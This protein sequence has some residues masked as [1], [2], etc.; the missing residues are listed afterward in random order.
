MFTVW[1]CLVQSCNIS[2]IASLS[3]ACQIVGAV[4][5]C[6][7]CITD[8]IYS[9]QRSTCQE[10]LQRFTTIK[11]CNSKLSKHTSCQTDRSESDR[12]GNF[13][14][15]WQIDKPWWGDQCSNFIT[16]PSAYFSV[17][18]LSWFEEFHPSGFSANKLE[19]K[20]LGCFFQSEHWLTLERQCG[21]SHW[22]IPTPLRSSTPRIIQFKIIQSQFQNHSQQS[23]PPNINSKPLKAPSP[24]C[25][26][27]L[28]YTIPLQV[29]QYPNTSSSCTPKSSSIQCP[30]FGE[31]CFLTVLLSW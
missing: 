6:R 27:P 11:K 16:Q 30:L 26:I 13:D 14:I 7:S 15:Y 19:L 31:N 24:S 1:L 9:S 22:A 5:Y 8:L 10:V 21:C 28:S 18:P 17:P 23:P 4:K 12:I 2:I 25:K 20:F 29:T 3:G